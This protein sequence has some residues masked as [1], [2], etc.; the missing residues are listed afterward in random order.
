MET[1]SFA[2]V[3]GALLVY[4]L[5][6]RSLQQRS[7]SAPLAFVALGLIAGEAGLGL[8]HLELENHA[9]QLIT[10]IT[11][12][13]ILFTDAARIDLRSLWREHT[14]PLRML[15]VGLPLAVAFGAVAAVLIFPGFSIWE[16]ALLAAL[17]APTDAALGQAV[18]S[19]PRVPQRIRQTLNAESGLNDGLALPI[20]LFFLACATNMHDGP[21][22]FVLDWVLFGGIQ[23]V[24]G[25]VVGVLAG[26]IGGRAVDYCAAQEWMTESFLDLSAVGLAI[27]AF[28]VSEL[29]GGNGFIAAFVAGLTLGGVARG[30]CGSL[31]KFGE[32]EGQLLSL[33]TFLI[34]GALMLP[35]AIEAFGWDILL[36][37]AL[38]LTVG[39]MVPVGLSLIGTGLS[40][41]TVFFLGWFGPR[42]LA[43]ILFA[44]VVVSEADLLVENE[45]LA[46]V[47]I[48]VALSVILHGITASPATRLYGERV[49]ALQHEAHRP[50]FQPVSDLDSKFTR[51]ED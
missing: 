32:A 16:A 10:E 50:E 33:L 34:F 14:L 4:G 8:L 36:Y 47:S 24:I 42:G 37:A 25:A 3:A 51:P 5:F 7:V 21:G 31:I 23:V 1:L 9:L 35:P 26:G 15:S 27:V 12:A 41:K 39:R 38:S 40:W 46:I 17:L 29:L 48:T 49:E 45:I 6:S 2:L 43:S 44:L 13:L 20:V 30:R 18:V 19:E 11:L 22:D 28:A